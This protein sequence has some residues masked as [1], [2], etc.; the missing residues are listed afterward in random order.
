[1]F[2]EGSTLVRTSFGPTY[3]R[4]ADLKREYDPDNIFQRNQNV[5]P[6]AAR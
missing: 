6:A 5:A 2:E 3:D 1:M 4:L